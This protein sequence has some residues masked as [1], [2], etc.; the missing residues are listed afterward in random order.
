MRSTIFILLA[1]LFV[2][3]AGCKLPQSAIDSV[4]TI[5]EKCIAVEDCCVPIL[6]EEVKELK[7]RIEKEE[8]PKVKALLEAEMKKC[9][10]VKND[11]P[12]ITRNVKTLRLL[13]EKYN[14]IIPDEEKE[15]EEKDKEDKEEEEDADEGIPIP[16][17]APVT[18]KPGEVKPA[19]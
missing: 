4:V 19:D 8:D 3:F 2:G 10:S 9:E 16:D 14:D 12:K 13:L 5:E 15:K 1:V 18:P 17:D 11:L 7:V 6:T